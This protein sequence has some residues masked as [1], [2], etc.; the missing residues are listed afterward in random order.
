M[1]RSK[2]IGN[3]HRL[4]DR[5]SAGGFL[6]VVS[7]AGM[8]PAQSWHTMLVSERGFAVGLGMHSF[9]S[10]N[11]V[12]RYLRCVTS[13]TKILRAKAAIHGSSE[14]LKSARWTAQLTVCK[15][16]PVDDERNR[17]V[18]LA[19]ATD[20]IAPHILES[21]MVAIRNM[22]WT[23]FTPAFTVCALFEP[24]PSLSEQRIGSI[25]S[26]RNAA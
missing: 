7:A 26:P 11:P 9:T 14:P 5:Q 16:G 15:A 3:T 24:N 17:S 25:L 8:D 20:M 12:C 19:I 6:P 10:E 4:A 2:N 21:L 22:N 13:N 18:T 23:R 1:D